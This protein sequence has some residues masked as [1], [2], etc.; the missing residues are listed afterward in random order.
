MFY[1]IV[2][3]KQ[4]INS[5]EWIKSKP[6]SLI[7]Q[8]HAQNFFAISDYIP[9]S[10]YVEFLRLIVQGVGVD[11]HT[12]FSKFSIAVSEKLSIRKVSNYILNM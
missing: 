7:I 8:I 11:N 9:C 3:I 12:V 10:N 1:L 6:A 4:L 5:L 2:H